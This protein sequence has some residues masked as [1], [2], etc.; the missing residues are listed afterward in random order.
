MSMRRQKSVPPSTPPGPPDGALGTDVPISQPA[1]GCTLAGMARA[2]PAVVVTS[3]PGFDAA[4]SSL[5]VAAERAKDDSVR[6]PRRSCRIPGVELACTAATS[7]PGTSACRHADSCSKP[8]AAA[9][10]PAAVLTVLL[11]LERFKHVFLSGTDGPVATGDGGLR[12]T[13]T[14]ELVLAVRD[15][16]NNLWKAH[17]ADIKR[18]CAPFRWT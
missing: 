15:A 11:L 8:S 18:I 10:Q 6:A 7:E 4:M 16:V 5:E 12:Q 3:H 9:E 2:A 14:I 13:A 17:E 1:P